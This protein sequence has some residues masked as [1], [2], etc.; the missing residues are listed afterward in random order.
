[1]VFRRL[2]QQSQLEQIVTFNNLKG[3]M[4]R[5]I[6]GDLFLPKVD[7]DTFQRLS[8][9][10]Y[11]GVV[12]AV[13]STWIMEQKL[14]YV[15]DVLGATELMNR[16][17][18]ALQDYHLRTNS[19]F[20]FRQVRSILSNLGGTAI[21]GYCI[22]GMA[23]Q[24]SRHL[25][26]AEDD[27]FELLCQEYPHLFEAVLPQVK[28]YGKRFSG[29]LDYRRRGVGH[30]QGLGTCEFHTHPPGTTCYLESFKPDIAESQMQSVFFLGRYPVASNVR[31]EQ[32]VSETSFKP[33]R[34]PP[35]RRAADRRP[36][37]KRTARVTKRLPR[38]RQ[39]LRGRN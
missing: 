5:T 28:N 13:T 26:D 1:V 16:M 22:T 37:R 11:Q 23:Y 25:Y 10:L 17:I 7:L 24:V 35:S 18:D 2:H 12:P 4:E 20:S 9:F 15:A 33:P 31:S 8:D 29:N 3:H 34:F 14:Y 32:D 19:H 36:R 38:P 27:E 6:D 21:W 39:R 30:T